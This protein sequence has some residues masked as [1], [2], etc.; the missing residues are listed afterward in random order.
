[1]NEWVLYW[2]GWLVSLVIITFLCAK[3]D[4]WFPIDNGRDD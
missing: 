3:L 1:M 4:D 2:S